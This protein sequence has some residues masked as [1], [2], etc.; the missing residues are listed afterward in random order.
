M[1]KWQ[2]ERKNKATWFFFFVNY[3]IIFVSMLWSVMANE[4]K[5]GIM[6]QSQGD[7][8]LKIFWFRLDKLQWKMFHINTSPNY[9]LHPCYYIW[10]SIWQLNIH[11]HIYI[12]LPCFCRAEWALCG[13]FSLFLSSEMCKIYLIS[14]SRTP[15]SWEVNLFT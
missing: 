3:Q 6:L 15:D 9:L 1:G 11:C 2:P 14:S 5:E 7:I 13:S 10:W 12:I 4:R 8:N